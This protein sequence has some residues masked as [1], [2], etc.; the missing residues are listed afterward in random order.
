MLKIKLT[1][2][3][4]A[5]KT[6]R[7]HERDSLTAS[8]AQYGALAAQAARHHPQATKRIIR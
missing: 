7:R 6:L 3:A 5:R 2:A 8:M 4:R 1:K